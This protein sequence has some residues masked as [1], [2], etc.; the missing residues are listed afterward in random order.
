[1]GS[2]G[3]I[4]DIIE[5]LSSTYLQPNVNKET[6]LK[7]RIHI[8]DGTG[9]VPLLLLDIESSL[10]SWK[11]YMCSRSQKQQ[12]LGINMDVEKKIKNKIV[13]F[14]F[15]KSLLKKVRFKKKCE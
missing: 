7:H 9:E 5:N 2:F 12:L 3:N 14:F 1:M 8:S 13:Q 11:F 4:Y 15:F 6:L 10:M